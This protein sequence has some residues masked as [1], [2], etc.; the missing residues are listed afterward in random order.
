MTDHWSPRREHQLVAALLHAIGP[1]GLFAPISSVL[2]YANRRRESRFLAVQA[3]QAALFQ[4]ISL[5]TLAATFLVFMIGFQYAAFSGMIA[6]TGVTNPELTNNL[7]IAAVVGGGLI[8]FLQFLFPLVGV[9]AAMRVL[10][11]GKFKYPVIGHLAERLVVRSH[12][13]ASLR[14]AAGSELS[15][16]PGSRDDGLLS[17]IAHVLAVFG[18]AAI[19][20]PV[21]WSFRGH[22]QPRVRFSLLQAALFDLLVTGSLGLI[23]VGVF[24]FGALLFFLG[25]SLDPR[26]AQYL[27]SAGTDQYFGIVVSALLATVFVVGRVVAAI[28]AINELRGKRFRYPIIG[29]LLERYLT[30]PSM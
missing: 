9:Y 30:R 2:V 23:F 5:V 13:S 27:P 6:D 24:I 4:F 18:L 21:I 11:Q 17:A 1:A 3:L 12:E 10:I 15:V 22:A 14:T 25:Q 20:N 19:L 29:T 7:I 26:G 28:G 16:P 8:F